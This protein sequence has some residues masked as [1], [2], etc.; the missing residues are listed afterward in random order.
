MSWVCFANSKHITAGRKN[1]QDPTSM[2][3]HVIQQIPLFHETT[4]PGKTVKV[5]PY[6]Q[7]YKYGYYQYIIWTL[8]CNIKDMG[9]NKDSLIL[10]YL[11]VLEYVEYINE[12][13]I[14]HSM[15]CRNKKYRPIF[16]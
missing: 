10:I 3:I 16:V 9:Q 14:F 6:V 1:F 8:I 7:Y 12:A 5:Q 2:P 15:F 11:L 4:T 13:L